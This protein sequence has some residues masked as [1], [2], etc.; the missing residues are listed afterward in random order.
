MYISPTVRSIIQDERNKDESVKSR[1]HAMDATI[2][3]NKHSFIQNA[4]ILNL[5]IVS[6]KKSSKNENELK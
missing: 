1:Y 6:S 2:Q 5:I 3:L 4:S